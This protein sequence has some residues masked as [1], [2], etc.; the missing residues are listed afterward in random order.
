MTLP[1][2]LTRTRLHGNRLTTGARLHARFPILTHASHPLLRGGAWTF[3]GQLG[4]QS[5]ALAANAIVGRVLG[6]AGFGLYS[7]AQT[8][9]NTAATV[10][11]YAPAL[12][13]TRA[14]AGARTS[15][16]E[17]QD[18]TRRSLRTAFF[19]GLVATAILVALSPRYANL[20]AQTREALVVFGV[21]STLTLPLIWLSTCGALL[22]GFGAFRLFAIGRIISAP[23]A[24]AL[25]VGGA[26]ALGAPGALL[27]LLLGT[28][29]I[30]A[31]AHTRVR[32]A[33]AAL[34]TGDATI[35]RSRTTIDRL[36]VP[37]ALS[38]AASAPV[39]WICQTLLATHGGVSSVAVIGASMVW[40]QAL[41]LVPTSLNQA[42]LAELAHATTLPPG[43]ARRVFLLGWNTAIVAI[44][45]L[46]P[47]IVLAAPIIMRLYGFRGHPRH[48]RSV[49]LSAPTQYRAS[50]ARRSRSWSR[51]DASGFNWPST[52]C[53]RAC[54][55]DSY[56][57]GGR[58]AQLA[59]GVPRSHPFSFTAHW[60]TS[61]P[62]I[63][64]HDRLT[65]AMSDCPLCG[66]NA[67]LRS[68]ALPGYVAGTSFRIHGCTECGV[69][70]AE[71][72]RE[73][74][75]VYK[76]IYA[77]PGR[78]PGYARYERYARLAATAADPLDAD[79]PAPF[80]QSCSHS[81]SPSSFFRCRWAVSLR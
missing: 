16:A 64:S 62:F 56:W 73:N 72:R 49:S 42:L 13:G 68:N 79:S 9:G 28:M 46:L 65:T 3:V 60:F 26:L 52:W 5:I 29:V 32:R 54:S 76:A 18:A 74:H 61:W 44:L 11:G 30:A 12:V 51:M 24:A 81:S 55:S 4:A 19:V 48:L 69:A 40:G 15:R 45:A 23:F 41:L 31:V 21:A 47:L 14:A 66:G 36:L 8:M 67:V 38:S 71:P 50:R 58:M 10:A 78:I 59:S 80:G 39:I 25:T 33:I 37:A 75:Q 7:L 70:F 22:A 2:P 17:A 35:A 43:S 57:C 20:I 6:P 63:S 53:G 1:R 77:K 27:G 34:P